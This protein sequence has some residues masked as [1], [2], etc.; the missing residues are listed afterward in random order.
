MPQTPFPERQRENFWDLKIP[1]VKF[2]PWPRK[3]FSRRRLRRLTSKNFRHFYCWY[4]KKFAKWFWRQKLWSRLG[5]TRSPH[6]SLLPNHPR[7]VT[8]GSSPR[9]WSRRRRTSAAAT[10]LPFRSSASPNGL[11]RMKSGSSAPSS[12]LDL[13]WKLCK[14]SRT[15]TKTNHITAL[16]ALNQKKV[17]FVWLSYH[18]AIWI[19]LHLSLAN[20]IDLFCHFRIALTTE[21]K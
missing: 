16:S 17:S 12:S 10:P 5:E 1:K 4:F 13:L 19:I 14:T 18:L 21:N 6:P 7:R 3:A 9:N 15:S 11:I 8:G 2:F 20:F